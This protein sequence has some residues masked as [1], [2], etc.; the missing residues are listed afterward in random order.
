MMIIGCDFHTRYQQIAMMEEG[1][2]PTFRFTFLCPSK[3]PRA[4]HTKRSLRPR[5]K[6]RGCRI[7]GCFRV[8]EVALPL[9]VSR[10]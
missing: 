8:R 6:F 5:M 7:P 3:H 9:T 2:W 1:G 4:I 10:F